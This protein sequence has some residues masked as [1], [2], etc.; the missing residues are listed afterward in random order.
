MGRLKCKIWTNII[1][2]HIGMI[3]LDLLTYIGSIV[4]ICA[5][6]FNEKN[7]PYFDFWG[8]WLILAFSILMIVVFIYK[9]KKT[10]KWSSITVDKNTIF[11]EYI[12]SEIGKATTVIQN[13]SGDLSWLQK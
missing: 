11:F 5:V 2:Q 4:T 12:S 3:L 7:I 10:L 1:Q 8:D 6:Y 13:I 9:I